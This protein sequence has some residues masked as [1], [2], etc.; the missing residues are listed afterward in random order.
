MKQA[1]KKLG[2]EKI[3]TI[4]TLKRSFATHLLEN[5]IDIRYIQQFL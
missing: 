5:G 3:A 1:L 4:H 2:F